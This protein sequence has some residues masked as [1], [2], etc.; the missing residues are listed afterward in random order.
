MNKFGP[1]DNV[2]VLWC[3]VMTIGETNN[4]S[5]DGV[6]EKKENNDYSYI[7]K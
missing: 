5:K 6:K 7:I 2:T 3:W 1:S 4:C